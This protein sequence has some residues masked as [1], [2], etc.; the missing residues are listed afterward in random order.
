MRS[1][2]FKPRNSDTT[3]PVSKLSLFFSSFHLAASLQHQSV[4]SGFALPA[5]CQL[6]FE[7]S[8]DS[9]EYIIIFF[10]QRAVC[11]LITAVFLCKREAL[12]L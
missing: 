8:I 9:C 6:F 3:S 7:T 2:K 4:F 5:C 1:L 11:N 12:H 10:S